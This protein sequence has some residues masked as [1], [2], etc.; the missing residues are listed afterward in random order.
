[1]TRL[2]RSERLARYY[3]LDFLD[4]AYDAELY[5]QLVQEAGGPVLELGV[6][7]GRLAIPLA[8]AGHEVVGIDNDPAMLQRARKAWD[9]TKGQLDA[10]RFSVHDGDLTTYRSQRHFG[11]ALIAV[12]T[13]LLAEDDDARLAILTTMREHLREGGIAVVEV[14]TPDEAELTRYDRRLQHEWLRRDPETGE[15]VSKSISAHHDPEAGTLD[16]TQIYEW[17][18]TEGGPLSRVT[19]IDTLHLVS[20]EHLGEL[21]SQAGFGE[22]DQRGDHLLTPYGAGSHRVILVARLV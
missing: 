4:V 2:E 8:L 17:T 19:K 10:D 9:E 18:P 21:A 5:Q 15:E 16:L 14:G 6:G 1:M 12:N 11:V 13:F 3:D 22:V 20:A 7:S